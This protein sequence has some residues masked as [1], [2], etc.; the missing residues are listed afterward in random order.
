MSALGYAGQQSIGSNRYESI[1]KAVLSLTAWRY[2]K[3]YS[4]PGMVMIAQCIANRHRAGQGTFFQVIER[5]PKYAA[6]L[7]IPAEEY[8]SAWDRDFLRLLPEIDA[9][10]DGT[11]KDTTNGALYW[12]DINNVTN[13][14]FLTH[15]ARNPERNRCADCAGTLV[16]W[17]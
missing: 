2:G 15:I 3:A 5:I 11:G 6:T 1:V 16:F 9:V 13:E 12:A 7:E 10:V 14:W 8:P 4:T 17:R